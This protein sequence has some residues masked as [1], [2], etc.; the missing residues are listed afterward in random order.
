MSNEL[1]E[2]IVDRLRELNREAKQLK[3]DIDKWREVPLSDH[4]KSMLNVRFD[5][6]L[7][8]QYSWI[9]QIKGD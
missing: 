2:L 6:V 4:E 9:N 3:F 1:L 5:Q 7:D 8:E